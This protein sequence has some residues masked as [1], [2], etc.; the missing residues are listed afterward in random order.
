MKIQDM[1][2]Q[3]GNS[4]GFNEMFITR[5]SQK[6]YYNKYSNKDISYNIE[7]YYKNPDS[8]YF[9]NRFFYYIN[10]KEQFHDAYKNKPSKNEN[11]IKFKNDVNVNFVVIFYYVMTN[12]MGEKSIYYKYYKKFVFNNLLHIYLKSKSY[13]RKII[14]SK[15]LFKNKEISHISTLTKESFI[16]RNL[17]LIESITS[18][19]S[20]NEISFR[21]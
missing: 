9:T 21:F 16:I 1:K 20:S 3:N 17:K 7:E 5:V 8:Q 2:I 12:K 6:V 18:F 14:I 10:N 19:I 4:K 11:K 13:R 15:K